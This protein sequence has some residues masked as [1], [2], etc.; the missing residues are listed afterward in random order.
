VLRGWK[1]GHSWQNVAAAGSTDRPQGHD[2]RREV[3]ALSRSRCCQDPQA[4]KDAKADFQERMKDRKYTTI[5]RRAEGAE[6]DTLTSKR[7]C[8]RM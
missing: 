2:G 1:S 3:L 8:A 6:D 7:G 4:L 5:I